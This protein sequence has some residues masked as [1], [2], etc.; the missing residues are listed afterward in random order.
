MAAALRELPGNPSSTHAAGRAAR[1]AVEEARAEVAALVGRRA[2]EIVFTSGGT[3]GN[4]L[5]IRGLIRGAIAAR[6]C[7]AARAHVVSSPLEHPSV[8]GAL[9]AEAVEVTLGCRSAPDG[10]ITPRGAARGAAPGDGA[11]DAGARE[12][13]A[14][15][16]LRRR[17]AGAQSPTR[18]ARCFTPTPCRRRARSPSTSRALGVDALT[19]SAHKLHGPKGVGAVYLRRGVPFAP[20]GDGRP[21][22][23]RA[24]RRDRERRRHRRLRR[25]GAAGASPSSTPRRRASA[26]LR[27]RLEARLLAIAGARAPRRSAASAA[28]YAQRRLRGR[29][30]P[31]R[32]GGAGPR[33]D[34]R[35]DG[36][37]VHV[38]LAGAVGG[39]AR[40]RARA[41]REAGEAIRFGL[42]RDN[43]EAEIDRVADAG[44]RHRRAGAGATRI[45]HVTRDAARSPQRAR[46][47][48][49]VGRRRFLGG[50]GAAGRA[51]LRR[52]RRDA[53][54]L[55]RQRHRRPASAG[56]AAGPRDIEDARA[57]AALPRHRVPRHRRERRVQRR[58]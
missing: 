8:L 45:G 16:R 11:G 5:A 38:G 31:V 57:T 18:R 50:G 35:L 1:A 24:P 41:R 25:R 56:A 6:G 48:R 15:Q 9:A 34:L 52:H 30:G 55:R 3:E 53:A 29:A 49:D 26:G 43:T 12:P 33:G 37:G 36:R 32:G 54:A 47:R 17:G 21:P 2:E 4:E 42:G 23:A 44:G 28:G 51:R 14:R 27:D 39:V 7:A 13:R 10:A 58:P 19:L 46:R 20:L 40:A 22:G